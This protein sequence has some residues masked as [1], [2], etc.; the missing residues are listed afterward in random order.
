MIF[1]EPPE[2]TTAITDLLVTLVA[3][4]LLLLLACYRAERGGRRWMLMYALVAVCGLAGALVHGVLLPPALESLLWRLLPLLFCLAALAYAVALICEI[5]DRRHCRRIALITT[6]CFTAG[7]AALLLF[8][9]GYATKNYYQVLIVAMAVVGVVVLLLL[10]LLAI[11]N[12]RWELWYH[13]AGLLVLAAGGFLGA[14]KDLLIFIVWLFD[15]NSVFHVLFAFVLVLFYLGYR[16]T[17]A[18]RRLRRQRSER[19]Q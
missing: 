15:A 12:R 9:D 11:R 3:L 8:S 1:S 2:L 18:V 19:E 6:L 7:F 10:I 16:Q 4:A 13:I 14:Q 5:N 17:P